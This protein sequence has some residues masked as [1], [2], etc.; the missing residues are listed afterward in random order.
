MERNNAR[1]AENY[2]DNLK[3]DSG[4]DSDVMSDFQDK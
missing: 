1:K 4:N 3:W 2:Y